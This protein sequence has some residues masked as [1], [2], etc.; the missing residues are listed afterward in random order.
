VLTTKYM[1]DEVRN[2]LP[3][4]YR[5]LVCDD[6]S[7]PTDPV[8]IWI[9]SRLYKLGASMPG[10]SLPSIQAQAHLGEL[11][12][13]TP[14]QRYSFAAQE[15]RSKPAA[16]IPDFRL[17]SPVTPGDWG[18]TRVTDVGYVD[19]LWKR[20]RSANAQGE[21]CRVEN[22]KGKPVD[23]TGR[24]LLP[25][26]APRADGAAPPARYLQSCRTV[27]HLVD[28][29]HAAALRL[30]PGPAK[31]ALAKSLEP[32]KNGVAVAFYNRAEMA[33][34][35]GDGQEI[36]AAVADIALEELV[37]NFPHPWEAFP[38]F[39]AAAQVVAAESAPAVP[40][41]TDSRSERN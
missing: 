17:V 32:F 25:A 28:A 39:V 29:A 16:E 11:M 30:A 38:S 2:V 10:L 24:E 14:A 4:K 18:I 22:S 8:A 26:D 13:Y 41:S 21:A 27:A 7:T 23:E 1:P 20:M 9:N 6:P 40:R 19:Q 12:K 37:R 35:A 3:E 34:Q 31:E 15:M 5:P 36:S 33:E